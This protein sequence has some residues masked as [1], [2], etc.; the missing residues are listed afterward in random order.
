M[1]GQIQHESSYMVIRKVV[2]ALKGAP[3]TQWRR[4]G[5]I[6]HEV[7]FARQPRRREMPTFYC[8]PTSSA[9]GR[10]GRRALARARARAQD[11]TSA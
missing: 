10:A 5:T 6:E 7:L 8:R 3:A 11:I 2:R 4:R 1:F 9:Y